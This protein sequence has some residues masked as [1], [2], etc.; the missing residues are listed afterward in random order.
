M[1]NENQSDHIFEPIIQKGKEIFNNGVELGLDLLNKSKILSSDLINNFQK[2][3]EKTRKDIFKDIEIGMN[4]F[5]IL[6]L[7]FISLGAIFTLNIKLGL[8]TLIDLE[9]LGISPII[10]G[11][12]IGIIIA[13]I[14]ID[15]QKKKY[16][17]L[18]FTLS[19]SGVSVILERILFQ[20]PQFDWLKAIITFINSTILGILVIYLFVIFIENTSILERGRVFSLLALTGALTIIPII[21]LVYNDKLLFVP[22]LIPIITTV[23]LYRKRGTEKIGMKKNQDTKKAKKNIIKDLKQLFNNSYL[24]NLFLIFSFGLIIGLII[25]P[26]RVSEIATSEIFQEHFFIILVVVLVAFSAITLFIGTIF[27]FWGRK[28][29]VSIFILGIGIINFLKIVLEQSGLIIETQYALMTIITLIELIM[30]IPLTVGEIVKPERY[31]SGVAIG[32]ILAFLSVFSGIAIQNYV[33]SVWGIQTLTSFIC[34]IALFFLVHIKESISRIELDW[35]DSLYHM[36]IV[37][38]SGLLI[39]EYEFQK[40]TEELA[41]SDLI[42]GGIIGLVTMLKE[43]TKSKD[44]LRTID[45]GNKKIMFLWGKNGNV[46]YVLITKYEL[47]ILRNKLEAFANTFEEYYGE[48]QLSLEQGVAM[49]KW[50][51][52]KMIIENFFT[53]KYSP[54]TLLIKLQQHISENTN[55]DYNK[56]E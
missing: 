33:E 35:P 28:M 12:F 25:P 31:G 56:K 41:S 48:K 44:K 14:L 53:R 19:F 11:L 24:I 16:P 13:I 9:I 38:E 30:L 40:D 54:E 8:N 49:E 34:I 47:F 6:Y 36:Y 51:D 50:Q 1:N 15:K 42:S 37:H 43:I 46:I 32:V 27:D 3:T 4:Q 21:A 7:L 5:R 26:T 22:G 10:I 2:K 18:I 39:Y 29:V 55:E 23:Y 20:H 45:H 17:I 52:T